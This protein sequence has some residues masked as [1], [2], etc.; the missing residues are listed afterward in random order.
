MGSQL[1]KLI[2]TLEAGDDVTPEEVKRGLQLQA[3]YLGE[4][5]GEFVEDMNQKEREASV[6][7]LSS[8]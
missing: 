2:E 3:L 7:Y 6:K 5:Y 1:R 4:S 8:Q